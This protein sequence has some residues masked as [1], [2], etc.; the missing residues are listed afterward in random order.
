MDS[1]PYTDSLW[2]RGAMIFQRRDQIR[3]QKGQSLCD[4]N[5]KSFKNSIPRTSWM[6]FPTGTVI[7]SAWKEINNRIF[8]YRKFNEEEVWGKLVK[9]IL[10]TVRSIQWGEKY[11]EF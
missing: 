6:M 5:L 3:G 10:E 9:N 2:D 11:K 8:R 1:F 4:W 7:W